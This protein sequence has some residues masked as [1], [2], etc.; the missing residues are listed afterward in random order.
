MKSLHFDSVGGASGDMILA[1]LIGLGVDPDELARA[2]ASLR[3]EP[4]AIRAETVTE[5]GFSG[6]RVTVEVAD[7]PHP[8]RRLADIRELVERSTLPSGAQ[9]R[10]LAVFRRLAEA[11]A[12]VHGTAPEA[13]HFHEVGAMDSIIDI[14]GA[15]TALEWLDV[16]PVSVSVLP[17]GT[18]T[19]ESAHGRLPV[20]APATVVLLENRP[21]IRTGEPFEL[22]TPTAA[23]WLTAAGDPAAAHGAA[24]LLEKSAAGFGHRRLNS[25]PNL[26]RAMLL[27]PPPRPAPAGPPA[28]CVVLECNLDD[29]VPELIGSLT[30][31]LLAAGALD[32]FTTPV[33]MKKQRP[34]TLLTV[35]CRPEDRPVLIDLI[36]TESTTFGVREYAV[37][38]TVLARREAA[39]TTPYGTVRLKI[40]AWQGRDVTRAP[41]HEDCAARAREHGVPVR[42]VYEA[43]LRAP[44]DHVH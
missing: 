28:A 30:G 24:G 19:I 27:A 3:I 10:G 17:L 37:S 39:V 40:G 8:H 16:G 31:R 1:C 34:G 22:V 29:A 12:A 35:L 42:A 9:R 41:E 7:R 20:P 38:R 36:F 25:R 5:G 43:A 32:V 2:L 13:V 23:A 4:F 26:L 21:V 6:L 15:C 33:Q 11:E 18:G 44:D 14:L